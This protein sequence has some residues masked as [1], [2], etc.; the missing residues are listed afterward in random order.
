MWGWPLFIVVY[1]PI[2][3]VIEFESYLNKQSIPI[4]ILG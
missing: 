2:Y 1:G 3:I 4:Q